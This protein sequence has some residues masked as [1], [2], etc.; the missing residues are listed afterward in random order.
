[1]SNNEYA[2]KKIEE[3]ITE[4][5]NL[6]CKETNNAIAEGIDKAGSIARKMHHRLCMESGNLNELCEEVARYKCVAI[7]EGN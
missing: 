7:S 2:M 5:D 1:M 4:I 3:L 6:Y